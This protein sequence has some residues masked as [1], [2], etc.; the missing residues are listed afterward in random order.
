MNQRALIEALIFASNK[1]L[2]MKNLSQIT[3]LSK[4]DLEKLIAEI[5]QEY[6]DEKHGVMLKKI[7]ESYTFL[8]KPEYHEYV[9]KVSERSIGDL[10]PSQIEVLAYIT[11]KGPITR[12]ELYEL[13]GKSVD[14]VLRELLNMRLITKRKSKR[15]GRPY[16]YMVTNRLREILHMASMEDLINEIAEISSD[17]S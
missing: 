15:K 4:K 8:T 14:N 17:N 9:E 13:R 11:F 1:P 5:H 10:T 6:S 7:S 3:G 2:S 16:E 12:K